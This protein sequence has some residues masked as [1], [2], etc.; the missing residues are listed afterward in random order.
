MG[1]R[2][3]RRFAVL[4]L[5]TVLLLVVAGPSYADHTGYA[6][7]MYNDPQYSTAAGNCYHEVN[8]GNYFATAF[9]KT[10]AIAGSCTQVATYVTGCQGSTCTDGPYAGSF[11]FFE[12]AQSDLPYYNV[13]YSH[14]YIESP[15]FLTL[16]WYS[17]F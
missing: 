11:G 9:S 3:G 13:V 8:H 2:G 10:R 7:S 5:T 1:F 14:Y 12:Y 15:G 16:K 17:V 6:G 4:V